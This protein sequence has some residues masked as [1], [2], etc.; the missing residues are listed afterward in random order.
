TNPL[1]GTLTPQGQGELVYTSFNPVVATVDANGLVTALS[2]GV[3]TI[4]VA[5]KADETYRV[6]TASFDISVRASVLTAQV[7][8][9]QNAG[10]VDVLINAV[11][12]NPIVDD[13]EL[14]PGSGAISY[15]S[16]D[17]TVALVDAGGNVVPASAGSTTIT[18]IK[19]ADLE[20]ASATASY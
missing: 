2:P 15:S 4:E 1:D 19:A 9:F 16:S 5:R 17:E 18:A 14:A 20:Y 12:S 3:T 6:A 13:P 11:A 10:P 7:I 8:Q